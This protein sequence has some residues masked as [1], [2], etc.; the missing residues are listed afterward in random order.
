MNI[1]ITGA[2]RGL[3][4]ELASESTSRGHHVWAGVRSASS[5]IEK[6]L[7]LQVCYP[8]QITIISLDTSDENSVKDA[9]A[10]LTKS[11]VYLDV[12]INSA[13]ILVAR[14]DKLEELKF[15][16]LARSFQINLFGPIMVLK[17]F[18]PLLYNGSQQSIINIS[19]ESL[20]F[21]KAHY[22]NFPYIL[23]KSGLNMFSAQLH[24]EL[25]PKG[26]QVYAVHPGWI[27]TDMGGVNAP[28]DA[29]ETAQ[30]ILNLIERK[31]EVPAGTVYINF[32]GDP[33]PL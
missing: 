1:L 24:R 9:S 15:D 8:E 10:E 23:S 17:H 29:T 3:G 31:T 2:N 14:Y 16:D 32:R 4:L 28:G 20:A 18:L 25:F 5:Q 26:F 27:K 13:A 33:M 11:G 7:E 21:K 6:L 22:G 19:T 30:G 12:V